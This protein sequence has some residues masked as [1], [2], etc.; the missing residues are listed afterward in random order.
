MVVKVSAR[1]EARLNLGWEVPV[2][3]ADTNGALVCRARTVATTLVPRAGV[4]GARA[5]GF[6]CVLQRRW[7]A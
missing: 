4:A 2:S 7:G 6:A 3:S 1:P 5:L